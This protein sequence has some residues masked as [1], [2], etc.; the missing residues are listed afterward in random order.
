MRTIAPFRWCHD[1]LAQKWMTVYDERDKRQRY[2]ELK[3]WLTAQFVVPFVPRGN[4]EKNNG[5]QTRGIVSA[6][7]L[8]CAIPRL[9]PSE[10]CRHSRS[11]G[12]TPDA[13]WTTPHWSE[14]YQWES[15]DTQLSLIFWFISKQRPQSVQG[16]AKCHSPP[17][18][19]AR[20]SSTNK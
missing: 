15:N 14:I 10:I 12:N 19:S 2:R 8:H 20:I 18:L 16:H 11:E 9:R 13:I 5:I 3:G 1:R 7:T 17:V 4:L 6:L